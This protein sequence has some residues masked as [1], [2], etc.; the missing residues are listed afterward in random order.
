MSELIDLKAIDPTIRGALA[1][2]AQMLVDTD[3]LDTAEDV[4][5]FIEKP[6]KYDD[7]YSMWINAGRP[8]RPDPGDPQGLDDRRAAWDAF[9]SSVQALDDSADT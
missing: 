9:Y 4:V 5:A 3:W 8:T 2:L 6:W 7:H 1:G